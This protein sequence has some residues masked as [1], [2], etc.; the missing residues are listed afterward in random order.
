MVIAVTNNALSRRRFLGAATAATGLAAAACAGMGGNGIQGGD[1]NTITFWSNHPG[2]SKKLELE[3]IRRFEAAHPGLH[4][5]LIDAGKNYEEVAEKFNAALVGG[6]LPDVV[7][8]SD[9]WWFNFAINQAISPLDP[10]LGAAGVKLDDYVDTFVDDYQFQG[11]HYA[12]PYCRSTQIFVYNQDVWSKAGLP[13]RGPQSWQEFDEWGPRIQSVLGP[14]KWAHG[15]YNAANYLAWTFEGPVWSFGGAYSEDWTLKFTDP[16]TIAAG[17][18]LRDM[19]NVKK[20]ASIRPQAATDFGTGVVASAVLSTG[21]LTGV[22]ANAKGKLSYATHFLPHP[23]GPGCTTGGAGLAIP[24][25]ISDARKVN[26]LKFIEFITNST[27]TAYFTQA[28]GYIPVRKS[29]QQDPSEMAFLAK[30]PNYQTAINQLPLTKSQDFGRVFLPGADQI[31]GTALEQIGL[32]NKT[33]ATAFADVE[34]Q[35]HGIYTRQIKP[36]L[37]K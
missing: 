33:P 35:L 18:T 28:T 4:V 14:R 1:P 16:A 23:H 12:L 25:R 37:S 8:L 9:V 10:Y 3:M 26:A 6:Q 17:N 31:I 7:I 11:R 5:Q 13:Q 30:N 20:Y 29:A 32:Q 22:D 34:N 36:K 15:W 27:N 2:T 19:I 24:A 21:D